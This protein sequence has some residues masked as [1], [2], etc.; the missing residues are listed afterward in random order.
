MPELECALPRWIGLSL[1]AGM[2]V[3]GTIGCT[4]IPYRTSHNQSVCPDGTA[5][6][7]PPFTPEAKGTICVANGAVPVS[8]ILTPVPRARQ[9]FLE[10]DHD[11]PEVFVGLAISGGGSRAAVFGMA[12]LEQ[13]KEIGILQHVTAISTTSG[14]GLAGAYYALNGT[15]INWE[16]ARQQMGTNFLGRW[17]WKNL[18]P[19]N[20]VSTVFTHED[21]SNLMADVFDES[22][23]DRATY[24]DL[25][26]FAVGSRPIWLANATD[27]QRGTR[28][29]FS[30]FQMQH[31][32]SS[33][34]SLPVSQA[35]MAS[36]AFPGVF[37]S[38]TMK[39][40]AP[41]RK[42][43]NGN[44]RESVVG[45]THLIDGGPTDNLGIEALLELAASHQRVR[46]SRKLSTQ[47][48]GS[49][50]LII[51]DAYPS[52]VPNRK[53]WDPDPRSWYDHVVD[54]NVFEAFDALLTEQRT[55]LLGSAGVET[56]L[57]PIGPRLR[58]RQFVLFDRSF[59]VGSQ[60]RARRVGHFTG[61][62]LEEAFGSPKFLQETP[63]PPN[64]FRC[65]AWHLNLSGITSVVPY[66]IDP[67][68]KLPEPLS[69]RDIMNHSLVE[70][71]EKLHSIVSQID[72]SFRLTGPTNCSSEFLLKSLYAAAF[73]LVREDHI[74][75][76]TVCKWLKDAGL[77]V[78]DKC[79]AFPENITLRDLP[80]DS[81]ERDAGLL[82]T[83]RSKDGFVRCKRPT[84]DFRP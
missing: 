81:V 49:C 79:G 59:K 71:R 39:H 18:L 50:F 9:V 4:V 47:A 64:H 20:L 84:I 62:E 55:E 11:V 12:V 36:A 16:A 1:V 73:V 51:A 72:T 82:A 78:S 77:N 5:P 17:L 65:A 80:L 61:K 7:F 10:D 32:S 37:N 75:Q 28:F 22:L 2:I 14:G 29:T 46:T 76:G 67:A 25:E 26:R 44:W 42:E 45:Y 83:G 57:Q 30:E 48:Q 35:V 34:A 15:G 69:N 53:M 8:P 54:L 24:G 6:T 19:W 52:G 3:V 74:N 13:L 56:S 66:V 27:A 31:S 68:T 40:Y 60:E 58:S 38:V 21:R 43:S 70:H 63:V 33:L 41:V 23:F